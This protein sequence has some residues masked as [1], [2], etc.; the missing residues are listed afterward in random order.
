MTTSSFSEFDAPSLDLQDC[1][2]ALY[3]KPEETDENDVK[4]ASTE[5]HVNPGIK[6]EARQESEVDKKQS[7]P[8]FDLSRP[9]TGQRAQQIS[10]QLSDLKAPSHT[11]ASCSQ[12]AVPMNTLS[13]QDTV[14]METLKCNQGAVPMEIPVRTSPGDFTLLGIEF[15]TL[16]EVS[17]NRSRKRLKTDSSDIMPTTFNW[18]S[19]DFRFTHS[20]DMANP[21]DFG[22][23][24]LEVPFSQLEN[25]PG[26]S[27][28]EPGLG[29]SQEGSAGRRIESPSLGA[30]KM[31]SRRAKNKITVTLIT[32]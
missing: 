19:T 7:T 20:T 5:E 11:D 18:D 10:S 9:L 15:E 28:Q 12:D 24:Q 29:S 14:P 22:C 26:V 6:T 2:I 13:S 31:R 1:K 16:A 8:I 21:D 25:Q 27:G 4:L 32:A 23:S 17:V 3:P 30:L